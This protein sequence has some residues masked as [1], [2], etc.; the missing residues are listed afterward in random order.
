MTLPERRLWAEL[1][2]M[3]RHFRR[4]VPVGRYVADFACHA[5]CLVVEVDGPPHQLFA[6]VAARD[7]ER[8]AWF[9]SQGYR[10]LRFT[11]A[12]VMDDLESVL[13]EIES[14]APPP[15]SPALP[16]SRGKGE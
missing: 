13:A 16:P 10:T 1:R 11:N 2:R 15:P 4:Q 7:R 3:G 14:A 6:E 5:R 12:E 8:D 9:A